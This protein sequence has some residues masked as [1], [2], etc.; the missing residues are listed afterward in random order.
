MY[1]CVCVCMYVCMYVCVCVCVYVCVR[2]RE[3]SF[4][5][6]LLIKIMIII[7][8]M[9]EAKVCMYVCV[10]VRYVCVCMYVCMCT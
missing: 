10:C 8:S 9:N 2:E 1:V 3:S 4:H 5:L 6:I 7:L